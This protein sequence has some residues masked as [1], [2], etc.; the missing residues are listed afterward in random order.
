MKQEVK[1]K[2]SQL[3]GM[4]GVYVEEPMC[5]HTTF[6]IGGPADYFLIPE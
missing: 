6:R 1:Q 2:F 5:R 3:L 4:Q